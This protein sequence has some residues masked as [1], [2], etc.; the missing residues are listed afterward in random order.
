LPDR[1]PSDPVDV[2]E[3][4][5]LNRLSPEDKLAFEDHYMTCSKCAEEVEKAQKFIEAAK[6]VARRLKQDKP[7]D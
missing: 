5:C 2:A 3:L 4:Y 7:E 1:C 6:A